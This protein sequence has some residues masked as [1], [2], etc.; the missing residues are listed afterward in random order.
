MFNSSNQ[1]L[2]ITVIIVSAL[3][4]HIQ[5][6]LQNDKIIRALPVKFFQHIGRNR[7]QR[8][9]GT[10]TQREIIDNDTFRA[11]HSHAVKQ[12]R[13]CPVYRPTY[14]TDTTVDL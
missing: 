5:T 3:G 8:E 1:A 7:P 6:I 14:R 2:L 4:S 12:S 13:I 10:A 9:T 11:I